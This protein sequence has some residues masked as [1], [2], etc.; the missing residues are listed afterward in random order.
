[1]Q[2]SRQSFILQMSSC[3]DGGRAELPP[4]NDPPGAR[5]CRC[6]PQPRSHRSRQPVLQK[7]CADGK[8]LP[9]LIVDGAIAMRNLYSVL[10]VAPKASDAEIKS[11]FRH[12]AKTCHPD[13]RPGD[14][15]AEEA[16][17]E[18]KRAYKFLSNPETRKVYDAFLAA[19]RAAARRRF[20]RAATTMCTSCLL[21][22]AS[23]LLAMVWLQGSGP[24]AGGREL[25]PDA[26]RA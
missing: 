17:Q 4:R 11:A 3:D 1:M 14:K 20:M 9:R 18:V 21:T 25:A 10:D 2:A 8:S 15:E 16:F 22:T 23:A 24:F 19:R 13:V 5:E 6:Y 26:A 7:A 12:L